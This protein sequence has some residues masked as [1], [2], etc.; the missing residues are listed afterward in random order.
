VQF[1]SQGEQTLA[2]KAQ[3]CGPLRSRCEYDKSAVI[4]QICAGYVS[5]ERAAESVAQVIR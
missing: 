2:F 4:A 1:P 3:A 5:G